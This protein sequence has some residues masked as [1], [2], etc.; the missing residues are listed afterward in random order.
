MNSFSSSHPTSLR[1]GLLATEAWVQE[2]MSEGQLAELLHI[3]HISLLEILDAFTD[4]DNEKDR[5]LG[6]QH[7][8]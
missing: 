1:M 2:L 4:V 3:D 8:Q 5:S 6:L 7:S